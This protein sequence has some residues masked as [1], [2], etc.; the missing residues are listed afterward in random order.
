MRGKFIRHSMSLSFSIAF[1]FLAQA[2]FCGYTADCDQAPK[3]GTGSWTEKDCLT[4][5]KALDDAAEPATP[6]KVCNTLLGILPPRQYA[7][8]PSM[9]P[10]PQDQINAAR[11]NGGEI[12]WEGLPA[13]SRIRVAAFMD[14]Q[15]YIDWYRP[16]MFGGTDMGRVVHPAGGEA[17]SI[18]KRGL[19]VTVVPE[20]RNFFWTQ[21]VDSCPPSKE[22]V[23]QLI[24]LN[25]RRP[26]EVVLEMW[27]NQED[28]YRPTP[29]PETSDHKADV[30]VQLDETIK[31][32]GLECKK[33][34]FP[35]PFLFFSTDQTYQ[36]WFAYNAATTYYNSSAPQNTAP[37]TRL[38]YTYDWGTP[39]KHAGASEFM[40]KTH[41][42]LDGRGT[43]GVYATY[44]RAIKD[45]D[46]SWNE[47]Y[48]CRW[49]GDEIDTD[50]VPDA[51][52]NKAAVKD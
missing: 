11:L 30:A 45:Y 46:K 41:P 19:W 21:T 43:T 3:W 51:D 14:K 17:V 18:L 50:K 47:Y 39:E 23:V 22:R 25:P 31:V 44:I 42:D 48:R 37:W 36:S 29:D 27:V 12:S 8:A 13:K 15:T 4:F 40:I 5:E 38:G 7:G 34:A 35:N 49:R 26:Y 16:C 20:L 2:G 24:G 9:P 28:L 33:W 10:W 52:V 32:W 1:M 6:E